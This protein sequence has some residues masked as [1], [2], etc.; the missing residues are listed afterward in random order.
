[1]QKAQTQHILD[2]ILSSRDESTWKKAMNTKEVEYKVTHSQFI[3]ALTEALE[4]SPSQV[5][6]TAKGLVELVNKIKVLQTQ[7][8]IMEKIKKAGLLNEVVKSSLAG[9]PT[10]AKILS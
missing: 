9:Y 1:M 8:Q 7:P 3:E 4:H 10:L 2:A 5:R 6:I